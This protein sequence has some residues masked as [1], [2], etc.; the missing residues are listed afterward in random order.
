[1]KLNKNLLL[2]VTHAYENGDLETL[3]NLEL[4]IDEIGEKEDFEGG[5]IE[6]LKKT[7]SKYEIIIVK[8]LA[9]IKNIKGSFPYN[10]KEFLKNEIL[11]Q[12]RKDELTEEIKSCKKVYSELEKILKELKGE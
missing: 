10:Q 2:Q 7:K 3:E 12:K 8:L 9:T 11:V 5:E 4:L 6:D 1:M